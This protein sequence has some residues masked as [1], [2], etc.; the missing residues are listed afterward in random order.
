MTFPGQTVQVVK[1]DRDR[2][3]YWTCVGLLA[4]GETGDTYPNTAANHAASS[5]DLGDSGDGYRVCMVRDGWV[6]LN[7][8]RCAAC[9]SSMPLGGFAWLAHT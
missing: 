7:Q 5:Q 6:R 8:H 4:E 1:S 3:A 9:V 2:S